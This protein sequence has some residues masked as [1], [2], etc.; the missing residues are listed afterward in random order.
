[1]TICRDSFVTGASANSVSRVV[2]R[3]SSCDTCFLA[4][5]MALPAET[6]GTAF[7][8]FGV[9][10]ISSLRAY[11]RHGVR[12]SR[13]PPEF[14]SLPVP[15]GFQQALCVIPVC[16][17]RLVDDWIRLDLP[18]DI[19][20]NRRERFLSA[21]RD[22]LYSLKAGSSSGTS[23]AFCFLPK[24]ETLT[25]RFGFRRKSCSNRSRFFEVRAILS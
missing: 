9:V 15:L 14:C 18:P 13:H 10:V 3:N 23:Y 24:T 5:L 1:M 12:C 22:T 4:G 11:A 7:I 16:L 17:R 21:L 2:I 6:P 20:V 8:V 25:Y 19:D